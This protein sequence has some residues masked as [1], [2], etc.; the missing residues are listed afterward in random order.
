MFKLIESRFGF[1]MVLSSD[2]TIVGCIDTISKEDNQHVI[3]DVY[4]SNTD[5]AG[6]IFAAVLKWFNISYCMLNLKSLSDITDR[7][8]HGS[9]VEITRDFMESHGDYFETGRWFGSYLEFL[10]AHVW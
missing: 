8:L 9:L 2:N 4:V 1:L 6:K 5:I 7:E 3:T 10:N